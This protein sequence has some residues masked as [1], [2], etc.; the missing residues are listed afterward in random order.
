MENYKIAEK[1]KELNKMIR[2][3]DMYFSHRNRSM[4]SLILTGLVGFVSIILGIN[5]VFDDFGFFELLLGA[6]LSGLSIFGIYTNKKYEKNIDREIQELTEEIYK[7]SEQEK[8]NIKKPTERSVL[9]QFSL[10]Y[11]KSIENIQTEKRAGWREARFDASA[12]HWQLRIQLDD[13]GIWFLSVFVNSTGSLEEYSLDK[14]LASDS[15]YIFSD[16]IGVRK[17]LYRPGDNCRCFDD[18]LIRYVKQYGGE[19]LLD[20]LYPYITAQYHFD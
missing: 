16:E 13:K 17:K 18:I 7:L 8:Q 6:F 5:V 4:V 19:A 12:D 15:H 1:T 10:S 9:E 11:I 3:R 14:E 20:E 2:D